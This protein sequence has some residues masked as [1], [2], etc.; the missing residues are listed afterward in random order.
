[1]AGVGD[2]PRHRGTGPRSAPCPESRRLVPQL[3]LTVGSARGGPRDDRWGAAEATAGHDSLFTRR[4]G[5]LVLLQ[6]DWA[7]GGVAVA[8]CVNVVCTPAFSQRRRSANCR[9]RTES[10]WSAGRPVNTFLVRSCS[11]RFALYSRNACTSFGVRTKP[12][13]LSRPPRATQIRA[14]ES[15][16]SPHR[17]ACRASLPVFRTR[18]RQYTRRYCRGDRS[19]PCCMA[20]Y[21]RWRARTWPR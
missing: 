16:M 6:P 3:Q 21:C 18:I 15:W 10:G 11:S 20:R 12:R 1:L 13:G 7:G 14:L 8:S 5:S 17:M 19:S 4:D 9:A 2:L